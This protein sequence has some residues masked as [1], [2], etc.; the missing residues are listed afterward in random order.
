MLKWK[1]AEHFDGVKIEELDDQI[2][3][4]I[5]VEAY[6]VP[7]NEVEEEIGTIGAQLWKASN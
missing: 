5:V 3:L 1:F 7:K 6:G 4:K 2:G